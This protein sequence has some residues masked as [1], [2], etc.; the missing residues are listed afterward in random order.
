[1]AQFENGSI[2]HLVEQQFMNTKISCMQIIERVKS[3]TPSFFKKIRNV[4]IVAAAVAAAILGAPVALPA[5][6]VKI[7]GYL[8][9]AGG[10]ASAVSQATSQ[11]DDAAAKGEENKGPQS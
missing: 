7:A 4:G 1:M 8:V 11:Q 9:V 6:V 2:A 3:P 10:I 5:V